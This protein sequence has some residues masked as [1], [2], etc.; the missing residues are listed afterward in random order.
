[1]RLEVG[2]LRESFDYHRALVGLDG[3]FDPNQGVFEISHAGGDGNS[4][5]TGAAK[6]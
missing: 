4:D 2:A 6:C 3:L 1:M 5:M